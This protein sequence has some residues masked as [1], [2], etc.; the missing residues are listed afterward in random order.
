[1]ELA[2]KFAAVTTRASEPAVRISTLTAGYRYSIIGA[3]RVK[4][5]F[6]ETVLLTII[7][8][9]LQRVKFFLPRRYGEAIS[10][11]DIEDKHFESEISSG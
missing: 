11:L 2:Q 5:Q 8:D 1:M 6:G 3:E 9:D 4:T 7:R 10:D